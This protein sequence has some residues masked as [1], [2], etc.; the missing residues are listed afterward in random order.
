MYVDT[1]ISSEQDADMA[2][3]VLHERFSSEPDHPIWRAYESDQFMLR[4][5]AKNLMSHFLSRVSYPGL[6]NALLETDRKLAAQ[7]AGIAFEQKVR[8]QAAHDLRS[9]WD[10]K[11]L[12]EVI[13]GFHRKGRSI[14]ASGVIGMKL[15][16]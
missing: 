9:G 5:R 6:A 1:I 3:S 8:Q 11:D 4:L 16:G 15:G 2:L 14:A 12:V 7:I 10:D 13:D